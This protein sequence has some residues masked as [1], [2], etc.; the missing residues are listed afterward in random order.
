V[1]GVKA[2]KALR[3]AD[4]HRDRARDR[5]RPPA[6]RRKL[7][8]RKEERQVGHREDD[9]GQPDPSAQPGEPDRARHAA[10]VHVEPEIGE[11]GYAAGDREQE[12]TDEQQPADAVGRQP[13]HED[14]SHRDRREDRQDAH[15]RK[16]G[17]TVR[18]VRPGRQQGDRHEHEPERSHDPGGDRGRT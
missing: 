9:V 18:T 10:R 5:H 4:D 1:P 7:A 8:G 12:S 2:V 14:R 15:D 3:R 16:E 13:C 11:A 6:T 17:T